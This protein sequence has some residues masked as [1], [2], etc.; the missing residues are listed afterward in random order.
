MKLQ[1]TSVTVDKTFISKTNF[2]WSVLLSGQ[3]T[4]TIAVLNLYFMYVFFVTVTLEAGQG[5]K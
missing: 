4:L 2:R 5:V 1:V 3:A